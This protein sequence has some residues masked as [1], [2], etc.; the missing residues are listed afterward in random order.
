[1]RIEIR[2]NDNGK[3]VIISF[4]THSE[5]FE[6]AGERNKFFRGL[7]GWDQVVPGERRD[8][9]YR[10]PGLLDDVPHMKISD[11]V[12]MVAEDQLKRV[13]EYFNQWQK[14]VEFEVLAVMLQNQRILRDLAR[15]G[16]ERGNVKI[17]GE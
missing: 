17:E 12:F 6:S 4:G 16:Q 15:K 11:S 3:A 14:K 10:R 5:H 8:Y 7:Y 9:H 13:L 2:R 1:M